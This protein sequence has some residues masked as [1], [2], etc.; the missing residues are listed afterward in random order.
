MKNTSTIW[1]HQAKRKV[2]DEEEAMICLGLFLKGSFFEDVKSLLQTV[3][4]YSFQLLLGKPIALSIGLLK[5]GLFE[6]ISFVWL[7]VLLILL[8]APL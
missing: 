2:I 8:R 5:S 7:E 6:E 3:Y 4:E 1:S